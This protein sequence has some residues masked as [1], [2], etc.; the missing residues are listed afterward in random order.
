LTAEPVER[1]ARAGHARWGPRNTATPA[2]TATWARA[3]RWSRS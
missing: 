1:F 3:T 2:C